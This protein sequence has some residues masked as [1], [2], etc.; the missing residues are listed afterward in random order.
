MTDADIVRKALLCHPRNEPSGM[1]A[2]DALEQELAEAKE[3]RDEYRDLWEGGRDNTRNFE[4]DL[5]AA[6]REMRQL[7]AENARLT[8]KLAR[9]ETELRYTHDRGDHLVYFHEWQE[10][11]RWQRWADDE[12][13]DAERYQPTAQEFNDAMEGH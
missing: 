9:A 3:G 10:F 6:L 4:A 12:R 8:T 7:L 11:D 13:K 5:G 1:I 2:L